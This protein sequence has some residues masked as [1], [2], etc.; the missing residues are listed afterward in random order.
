MKPQFLIVL[1]LG[2]LAAGQQTPP[3][4]AQSQDAN[5]QKAH[6]IIQQ[7]IQALGGQAYLTYT[8]MEQ[9]GRTYG[10]YH[11]ESQGGGTVFWRFWKWPDKDRFE[12]TKERDVIDIYNGDK[13]YE[14]TYKGVGQV[15][16]EAVADYMRR[17]QYSIEWVMRRWIPDSTVAFFYEGEAV[18]DAKPADKVT[19]INTRNQSVTL[20]L[21]TDTPLPIRKTF[22]WRDTDRTLVEE[23]ESWDNYR[24]VQGIMTPHSI[25]RYK[26]GE[27]VNQRFLTTITYNQ[28]LSDSLFTAT[29][30]SP[31]KESKG[32]KK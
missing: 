18:A 10:F 5:A 9:Q 7:A 29:S 21:S 12:L 17:R 26:S 3:S 15:D 24:P 1:L 8:D 14:L 30:L 6:L 2:A 25:T 23:A 11:G 4:A 28:N 19:L 20:Y 32:K 27:I 13:A 16:P 22:Q 31:P